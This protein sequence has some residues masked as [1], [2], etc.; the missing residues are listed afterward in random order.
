[1]KVRLRS[2]R[3]IEHIVGQSDGL[4]AQ[5]TEND[6]IRRPYAVQ[7]A[8][9]KR[10][11]VQAEVVA[12]VGCAHCG[13]LVVYNGLISSCVWTDNE[14]EKSNLSQASTKRMNKLTLIEQMT[15]Q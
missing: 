6:R 14:K 2:Q 1:M 11:R 10:K 7:T 8:F 5:R 15:V 13:S 9:G 12:V 3:R 4:R